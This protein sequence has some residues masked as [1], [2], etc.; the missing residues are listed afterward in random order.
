MHGVVTIAHQEVYDDR[1]Y[2]V[3]RVGHVTERQ[4]ALGR[5][6]GVGSPCNSKNLSLTRQNWRHYFFYSECECQT[7]ITSVPC[8]TSQY[9]PA[10]RQSEEIP[11]EH[12]NQDAEGSREVF[13]SEAPE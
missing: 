5:E 6:H 3:G 7:Y 9:D 4:P 12:G 2:Q 1:V 10:S 11:R 8:K 13:I